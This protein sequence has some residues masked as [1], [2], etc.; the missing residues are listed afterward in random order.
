[1]QDVSALPF[2]SSL[3]FPKGLDWQQY[4]NKHEADGGTKKLKPS[5][6]FVT[7]AR[8]VWRIKHIGRRVHSRQSLIHHRTT[9]KSTLTVES[10][11]EGCETKRCM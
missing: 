2:Q 9:V 4:Q 7:I 3:S 1:M 6:K 10:R 11:E 8:I 5:W